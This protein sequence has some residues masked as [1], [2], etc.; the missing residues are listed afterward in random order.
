MTEPEPSIN[1]SPCVD[2]RLVDVS[3]PS[4]ALPSDPART[5]EECLEGVHHGCEEEEADEEGD[6]G[7]G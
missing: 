1:P 7:E 5:S 3:Q 6:R 2:S 4:P